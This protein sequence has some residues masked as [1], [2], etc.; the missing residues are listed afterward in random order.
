M[1]PPLVKWLLD[2]LES[3][4]LNP[5]GLS[6]EAK[7]D[8]VRSL[9]SQLC[10]LD[11]V[12][13]GDAMARSLTRTLLATPAAVQREIVLRLPEMVDA[14]HHP[15]LVEPL[16]KAMQRSPGLTNYVLEACTA[17]AIDSDSGCDGLDEVR[18]SLIRELPVK[19]VC[20]LPIIVKFLIDTMAAGDEQ[21]TVA[22][23][24]DGLDLT[25]GGLR[26][27]PPTSATS[28]QDSDTM[29]LR[30]LRNWVTS[31]R[32]AR[33]S[34]LQALEQVRD[35]RP[36]DL[37]MTLVLRDLPDCERAVDASVR[38][39]V[40]VG[41]LR[42]QVVAKTLEQHSEALRDSFDALLAI[43]EALCESRE[44]AIADFAIVLYEEAFLNFDPVCKQKIIAE[45]IMKASG[46]V[47][48]DTAT[49]TLSHLV[50]NFP[51]KL[52]GC[53]ALMLGTILDD[54][55]GMELSQARI[56]FDLLSFLAYA[57]PD[58]AAACESRSL[59]DSLQMVI[60]KQ[61]A[62]FN[63]ALKRMGAVGVI[64]TVKNM[65]DRFVKESIELHITESNNRVAFAVPTSTWRRSCSSVLGQR[66]GASRPTWDPACFWTSSLR[67]WRRPTTERSS[68]GSTRRSHRP[69]RASFSALPMTGA[70]EAA[71]AM[72]MTS[73]HPRVS[74]G[75][76]RTARATLR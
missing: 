26:T 65:K 52:G 30:V 43:A 47:G 24:R 17:L 51:S 9:L 29:T 4:A 23:L 40:R 66:Q 45:L 68:S 57:H 67:Q 18:Q 35:Q 19:P 11:K 49:K 16:K 58:A 21:A 13:D 2:H 14:R 27:Q 31:K 59:R 76:A 69:S 7:A 73:C 38:A 20:D 32:R 1:Q 10:Y 63:P 42:R 55:G 74:S 41:A 37:M 53:F 44:L 56:V 36:I 22:E 5:T 75:C 70:A 46:S 64:M 39:K 3:V 34:W 6:D 28:S 25:S 33:M 60:R 50:F 71:W 12:V 62:A 15:A 54:I 72:R 48:M 61:V 8:R